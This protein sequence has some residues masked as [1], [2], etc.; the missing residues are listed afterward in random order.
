MRLCRERKLNYFLELLVKVF[1]HGCHNV[2]QIVFMFLSSEQMPIVTRSDCTQLDITEEFEF[3]FDAGTEKFTAKLEEVDIDFNACQG[4]NNRNNDL[5][6]Y[7]K[8]LVNR[9]KATQ[10]NLEKLQKI[11]VGA[12]RGKCDQAIEAFLASKGI[13]LK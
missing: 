7:Y 5:E 3:S 4:A 1:F 13:Q 11:L 2:E 6:A 12:N 8:R 10:A 9:G